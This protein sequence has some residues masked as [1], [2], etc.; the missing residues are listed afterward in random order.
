MTGQHIRKMGEEWEYPNHGDLMLK[1]GLFDIK[2]YIERRRGTLRK[3]IEENRANL[4]IEAMKIKRHCRDVNKI[5]WW[6]QKWI[7]KA[8]MGQLTN[9]W[10]K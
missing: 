3:Y 2:T 4:L 1:C 7:T 5:M 6:E 10:F 9:F 8:E